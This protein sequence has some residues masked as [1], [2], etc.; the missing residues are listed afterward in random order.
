MTSRIVVNSFEDQNSDLR[1]G[2]FGRS[3]LATLEAPLPA[4]FAENASLSVDGHVVA[5]A[6]ES[7]EALSSYVMLCLYMLHI[8]IYN[9]V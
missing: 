5:R 9:I 2:E 8:N 4:R 3:A 6:S 1:R 7:P